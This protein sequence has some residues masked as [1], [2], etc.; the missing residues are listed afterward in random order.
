MEQI[1]YEIFMPTLE[2]PLNIISIDLMFYASYGFF[3]IDCFLY[4]YMFYAIV[5]YFLFH[6]HCHR[7]IL[8]F[9]LVWLFKFFWSFI[10]I[11]G[12]LWAVAL[13]I[14]ELTF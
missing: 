4:Y 6:L 7:F 12:T 9:I 13:Q 3:F 14:A 2:T 11:S 8:A 10:I 1:I 5:I